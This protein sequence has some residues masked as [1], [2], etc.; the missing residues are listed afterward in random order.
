MKKNNILLINLV[1][2]ICILTI[3]I[4]YSAFN[5]TFS[6]SGDTAVRIYKDIRITGIKTTRLYDEASVKYNPNYSTNTTSTF[7]NLVHDDSVVEYTVTL[8]NNSSNIYEY[9]GEEVVYNTE[10]KNTDGTF[11]VNNE[12]NDFK[13]QIINLVE[14]R[15]INPGEEISFILKISFNPGGSFENDS[16]DLQLKYNFSIYTPEVGVKF[17]QQVLND[18][19]G[20]D[21]IQA[22]GTPNFSSVPT[23]DVGMYAAND[24]EG[25]S[26]YFRG[27]VTNNYVKFAK[28]SSGNDMWWRIVRVN[29]ENSVRMVYQG[30]SATGNGIAG[31]DYYEDSVATGNKKIRYHRFVKYYYKSDGVVGL[32]SVDAAKVRKDIDS[33]YETNL[34]SYDAYFSDEVGY[35]ND[36]STSSGT[37]ND[38]T[39]TSNATFSGSGRLSSN[40]PVL[41]CDSNSYVTP[42]GSSQGTKQLT[43]PVG[44]LSMDEVMMAGGSSSDNTNYYLNTGTAFW[45]MTPDSFNYSNFIFKLYQPYVEYVTANGKI[46]KAD[47][48]TKYGYRP[49]VNIDDADIYYL[50]GNGSAENPYILSFGDPYGETEA[51]V[52]GK[53]QAGGNFATAL[54]GL[55]EQGDTTFF[56]H[57]GSISGDAGDNN[58]RFSGPD[59]NN[60]VCFGTTTCSGTSNY[61]NLFRVLGVYDDDNDGTYNVKLISADYASTNM[62]GVDGNYTGLSTNSS[63]GTQPSYTNR[64]IDS[65]P[66]YAYNKLKTGEGTMLGIKYDKYTHN[67]N[68]TSGLA[69]TNLNVN[70]LNFFG[71]AWANKIVNTVWHSGN[72]DY[73]A[74][75]ELSAK[76]VLEREKTGTETYT[77]K[78]G[79]IYANEYG[80]GIWKKRWTIPMK[81]YE[82][83]ADQNWLNMGL[84]EWTISH[85]DYTLISTN[86][87]YA[88]CIK[89]GAGIDYGSVNTGYP[90]RPTFYI[91]SDIILSGGSGTK[92]DP[93]ILSIS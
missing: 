69:L 79:L 48:Y 19:G 29:G 70:L 88:A 56:K 86:E 21:A 84:K 26:Y 85:G 45:T 93:Y 15:R 18:N 32:G 80:Y 37:Y 63:N 82:N 52:K 55:T 13:Y 81:S 58:Y 65:I 74:S 23:T 51:T 90:V 73:F 22:R 66:L 36:I 76:D 17:Y 72:V 83:Y 57:D 49:V 87:G 30:T 71:E 33:W 3:S 4:G 89:K 53:A 28:D 60:Y 24:N 92:S 14:G 75:I 68:D 25:T 10:Y 46:E 41:T 5:S 78:I 12:L 43:Y 1:I 47:V 64:P 9:T 77:K 42:T 31:T 6:I 54:I 61:D 2:F 16:Q 38:L 34:K 50:S 40:A 27:A 67:W 59:P 20:V 11:L 7:S 39:S 44:M 35:C 91:S 8:K 62:L